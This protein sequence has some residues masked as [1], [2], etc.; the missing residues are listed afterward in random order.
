MDPNRYPTTGKPPPPPR[1]P[2]QI[3]GVRPSALKIHQDSHKIKKQPPPPPKE[4]VI[5]YAVSP[6]IIHTEESN[7]MS[8]VQRLTGLSSDNFFHDGS[9]SPAARLAATEKAS[10][11]ELARPSTTHDSSNDD[12]MELLKEM[13]VGQ[14][15][16]ILSP[17]PAMLPPVPT[18]FFSPGSTDATSPSFLNDNF[19]MSPFIMAS[20]SGLFPGPS[21]FSPLRSP[22]FFSS[23]FTDL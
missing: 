1:K 10:P 18:G 12:L 21:I 23:L 16:G 5:I 19:N 14:F 17:A 11:R 7:F 3:Q 13:D 4:P 6:K 9:V 2:I 8:V 20:P 22:D 15:P